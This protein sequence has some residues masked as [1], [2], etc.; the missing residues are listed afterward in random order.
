MALFNYATKEIT[1]KVVYY[2]PGLCGKTTNL[3]YLH[4]SMSPEKTGKLLSLST[5]AD[6]TLFFDF[7][8]VHLGRIKDFNVRFQLYTVPGQ[9]RYNATRKLVLKG[10]DA[11]VFVA[12]SQRALKE[13]NVESLENMRENLTANNIDPD[14]IPVILQYNKRD[15]P[16]TLSPGELDQDLN[17]GG[18]TAIHAVAVDGTGVEETFK[19]VT[20]RLL[21]HISR[22]HNV[23]I[24]PPAGGDTAEAAA[25]AEPAKNRP[26]H[27]AV[28]DR[29]ARALH[30]QP[31]SV[32]SLL[33][34][35]EIEKDLLEASMS[36]EEE[37]AAGEAS[38]WGGF[39][40]GTLESAGS[41][42]GNES[43]GNDAAGGPGDGTL[44]E[45]LP[46]GDETH[47]PWDTAELEDVRTEL[48]DMLS[49]GPPKG[50]GPRAAP[51]ASARGGGPGAREATPELSGLLTRVLEEL[52]ETKEQQKRILSSL[53]TIELALL[54]SGKSAA[55]RGQG[56]TGL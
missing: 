4:A 12:D 21:D 55:T 9:V 33:S 19:L 42:R 8:P 11:V 3:Q 27:I 54:K 37:P 7:M 43:G 44:G 30:D 50:A 28:E 29:G 52:R 45:G 24:E 10:A 31:A 20:R 25:P 41:A 26:I 22:K 1:L 46:G 15:L 56:R 5:D 47:F 40:E 38:S 14:D 53:K 16:N 17:A 6:R 51:R 48:E 2:G 32:E 34:E 23:Q 49:A 13:Q 35:A 18:N 39:P 36:A